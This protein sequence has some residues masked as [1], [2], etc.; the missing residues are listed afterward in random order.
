MLYDFMIKS[1]SILFTTGFFFLAY[2]SRRLAGTSYHPAAIFALLWGFLTLIPLTAIFLAP[3]NPFSILYILFCTISFA[4]PLFIANNRKAYLTFV[5]NYTGRAKHLKSLDS[6]FINSTLV[7]I[8][9]LGVVFC[10]WTMIINGWSI[11]DMLFDLLATSGRFAALRGNEGMEYGLIGS[12]GVIFTYASASLGGLIFLSKRTTFSRSVSILLAMTPGLLAMIIQSSKL[13]FLIASCF[14]LSGVFL[15]NIYKLKPLQLNSKTIYIFARILLVIT[16]FILISFVSREHYGDLDDLSKTLDLLKFA[17]ASYALGQIYAFSDFF[18]FYIGMDSVSSYPQDYYRMGVY[19]FSSVAE[20][21]GANIDFPPGLY[22]E[23]G[24]YKDVFETN[25]F[26]IFRGFILDF[27]ILGSFVVFAIMGLLSNA[28][29]VSVLRAKNSHFAS[30]AY[31]HIIVFLLM[32]YLIS[33]FMPRYMYANF[34]LL[35]AILLV[36]NMIARLNISSRNSK[37][38]QKFASFE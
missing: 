31:M 18:S 8:S 28:V 21:F 2:F 25:V 14:F 10:F 4:A 37:V 35:G 1:I 13:I 20:M 15:S 6:T 5:N 7:A 16:P 24:W 32:T 22:L 17:M 23:T 11:N 19:T 33:V 27:G 3:I 34:A 26:T 30:L 9:V 12:L 29:F 38:V 36:N